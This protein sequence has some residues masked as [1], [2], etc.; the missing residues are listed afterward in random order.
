[1]FIGWNNLISASVNLIHFYPKPLVFELFRGY[2]NEI[3]GKNGLIKPKDSLK[4]GL[5]SNSEG[6]NMNTNQYLKFYGMYF[7]MQNSL[8]DTRMALIWYRNKI[9]VVKPFS[10]A[11]VTDHIKSADISL[12]DALTNCLYSATKQNG[13]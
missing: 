6:N 10:V 2:R 13:K 7:F 11:A 8:S 4:N 1:M 5:L 12:S 3:L 9:G